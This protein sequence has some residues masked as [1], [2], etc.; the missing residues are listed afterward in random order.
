ME[1]NT[2]DTLRSE[3]LHQAQR[4]LAGHGIP[5]WV[6]VQHAPMFTLSNIGRDPALNLLEAPTAFELALYA[7][8]P[9]EAHIFFNFMLTE[10]ATPGW[11]ATRVIAPFE[12]LTGWLNEK[13]IKRIAVNSDPV[14]PRNDGLSASLAQAL[15]EKTHCSLTSSSN[16]LTTLWQVKTL[17]EEQGLRF[18]QHESAA[19]LEALAGA[20]QIGW[21]QPQISEWLRCWGATRAYTY[22]WESDY[23]TCPIVGFGLPKHHYEQVTPKQTMYV[24]FSFVVRG[25]CSD[26]Q[27]TYYVCAPGETEAPAHIAQA[28]RFGM[29]TIDVLRRSCR[30]GVRGYEAFEAVASLVEAEGFRFTFPHV[31][32]PIGRSVNTSGAVMEP[33]TALRAQMSIQAGEVYSLPLRFW[34]EKYND[35]IIGVEEVVHVGETAT[36]YLSPPQD[37][38]WLVNAGMPTT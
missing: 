9:N 14:D 20:M 29:D 25:F 22:G 3:K 1:S 4:L 11:T 26:I 13:G 37:R 33:H 24:D 31:G 18:S 2:H 16:F 6:I 32:H 30:P 28:F 23:S 12:A 17:A 19:A 15:V 27:R 36:T 5:A 34:S 35:C 10:Q 7:I 21:T 38:V 8:T